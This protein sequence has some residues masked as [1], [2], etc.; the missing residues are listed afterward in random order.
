MCCS[1]ST[2]KFIQLVD[3][4]PLTQHGVQRPTTF[5]DIAL[6]RLMHR[7]SY[8]VFGRIHFFSVLQYLVVN[9]GGSLQLE[10]T[11]LTPEMSKLSMV[12]SLLS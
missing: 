5:D 10:W 1:G 3:N 4:S 6:K 11:L 2:Q 12:A 8:S 9:L 7:D